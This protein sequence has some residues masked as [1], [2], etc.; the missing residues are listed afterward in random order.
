M[1]KVLQYRQGDIL[2]VKVDKLHEGFKKAKT[3]IVA[4]GEIT[5]HHHRLFGDADVMVAD[6]NDMAVWVVGPAEL[7]HEEHAA[8]TL[9][10]GAYEVRRQ[11][12]ES[13]NRWG[14]S[15]VRD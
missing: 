15:S 8:I 13:L 11:R 9:E 1:E 4:E 6:N 12:E 2:L 5:G 7:V 10:P 3:N 14:W